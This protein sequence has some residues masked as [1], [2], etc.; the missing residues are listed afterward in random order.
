MFC[1]GRWYSENGA[2]EQ[3]EH[4]GGDADWLGPNE[5]VLPETTIEA[6]EIEESEVGRYTKPNVYPFMCSVQ[7]TMQAGSALPEAASVKQKVGLVIGHLNW[8]KLCQYYVYIISTRTQAF[9]AK[10]QMPSLT[11]APAAAMIE[12]GR[13]LLSLNNSCIHCAPTKNF[14]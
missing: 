10:L 4:D 12:A 6:P 5:P 9:F 13:F 3:V 14:I 11:A 7:M 2:E 8:S 1:K